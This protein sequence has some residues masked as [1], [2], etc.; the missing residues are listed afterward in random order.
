MEI[1]NTTDYDQDNVLRFQQFNA[2]IAKKAP[3]STPALFAFLIV[4]V[5]VGAYFAV[6]ERAWLYLLVLAF[7]V[8]L[9]VRRFHAIYI[10]PKKKFAESS[11]AGLSQRYTF[12][13]NTFVISVN[14]KE[15]KAYYERLFAVWETPRAFY[16]YA[17]AQQAYIV[18]K[19]G[20]ESGT[21]EQL[22]AH[23]KSRVDAKKYR[24]AKR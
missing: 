20:F 6:R 3:W 2:R 5:A 21:A 1:I 12:H 11:F 16:L 18:S 4:S 9:F 23:L 24:V 13:K 15:D 19:D 10:A 8:F 14:G 17:N 7:A 22:A